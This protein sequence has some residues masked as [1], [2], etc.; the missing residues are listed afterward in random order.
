MG[1]SLDDDSL[2]A[3]ELLVVNS[4]ASFYHFPLLLQDERVYV[5]SA[6]VD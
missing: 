3:N 2:E 5:N 6:V 4:E 1:D